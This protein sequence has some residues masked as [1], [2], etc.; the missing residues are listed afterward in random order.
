MKQIFR[1]FGFGFILFS[2]LAA[3]E[4][5][6]YK[7]RVLVAFTSQAE[8]YGFNSYDAAAAINGITAE[9]YENSSPNY[10]GYQMPDVELAGTVKV[11]YTGSNTGPAVDALKSK[12]DNKMDEIHGL[13]DWYKADIVILV[14]PFTNS[15]GEAYAVEINHENKAFAVVSAPSLSTTLS[16]HE[17]GHLVGCIHDFENPLYVHSSIKYAYGY[18]GP[19][20]AWGT[21]MT[22]HNN[23]KRWFSNP[24]ETH[25][26]A[27]RGIVDSADCTRKHH[28]RKATIS[29][30]RTTP[31]GLPVSNVDM[32]TNESIFWDL[33]GH[34]WFLNS[35]IRPQG[36][37]SLKGD[38][39]VHFLGF[40]HSQITSEGHVYLKSYQT[41]ELSGIHAKSSIVVAVADSLLFPDFTETIFS[42]S[43][44]NLT[45]NVIRQ[46]PEASVTIE[47]DSSDFYGSTIMMNA[48]NQIRLTT[49]FKI[50]SRR[51]FMR[52]S[53][54]YDP[55]DPAN[56]WEDILE[57]PAVAPDPSI[58]ALTAS[59]QFRVIQE[60]DGVFLEYSLPDRGPLSVRVFDL[61]GKLAGSVD[62]RHPKAG[63][64]TVAIPGRY[65]NGT[66][67]FLRA[68]VN[69][70][71]QTH[72]FV[73][74]L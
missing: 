19:A 66:V 33:T 56:A 8:T 55:F 9:V 31:S 3:K 1:C 42:S 6:A 10:T 57:K 23:T 29:A 34:L 45:A 46:M 67:Y 12:T 68:I 17:I 27:P 48:R 22:Y 62:I 52:V 71:V 41:V 58:S 7:I 61:K 21:V 44:A 14:H 36:L 59:F 11:S 16:A 73:K 43:I 26:G 2:L 69:G 47:T 64:H 63:V 54:S 13:R 74:G 5:K 28:E 30:Y 24:Y 38:Q 72:R 49:G 51:V 40:P 35:Q 65:Q 37:V 20:N 4:T 15:D 50:K 60:R 39:G 53:D 32:D 18:I 70:K 25:N